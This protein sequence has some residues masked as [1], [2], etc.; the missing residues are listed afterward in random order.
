[1]MSTEREQQVRDIPSKMEAYAR[2][3][4]T[5]DAAAKALEG[6][7][8]IPVEMFTKEFEAQ[9][10]QFGKDVNIWTIF[11]GLLEK[12]SKEDL[13]KSGSTANVVVS[14]GG[15]VFNITLK[16][17][18]S[19]QVAFDVNLSMYY[20]HSDTKRLS[21]RD[22]NH[23]ETIRVLQQGNLVVAQKGDMRVTQNQ[24]VN[25]PHQVEAILA[26]VGKKIVDG[27]IQQDSSKQTVQPTQLIT[28]ATGTGKGGMLGSVASVYGNG[29]FVVPD[30]LVTDAVKEQE[31]F[32][33]MIPK[34]LPTDIKAEDVER[35]LKDNPYVVMSHSQLAKFAGN[36]EG[37]NIFLDEL[38]QASTSTLEQLKQHKNHILGVTA[39]P[40]LGLY[41]VLGQ[42]VYD[43]SL[44]RAQNELRSV[45]Q[46]VCRDGVVKQN[47][48]SEKV[49]SSLLTRSGKVG[50]SMKGYSKSN[51][52]KNVRLSSQV[53]GMV[54]SD[55]ENTAR[56]V[57]S[58][59][60]GLG[61][62]AELLGKL[63]KQASEDRRENGISIEAS[64][65][66]ELLSAQRQLIKYSMQLE[67]LKLM[68]K[69][70]DDEEKKLWIAVR[71]G[72]GDSIV[73]TKYRDAISGLS[74]TQL[75]FSFS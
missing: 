57:H 72:E 58:L 63:N 40:N 68:G 24:Y 20:L 39:T 61:S 47:E 70:S 54:F 32:V 66:L 73:A 37:Q 19:D 12:A 27:D 25:R 50:A 44:Y 64:I 71:N 18:S 75:L 2:L 45:R 36:L 15:K 43:L 30:D 65:S 31:H 16:K 8:S 59:L 53:Q 52:Q 33:G 22:I 14:V 49:V 67:F 13:F 60:S 56:Q 26:T 34:T 21:I 23:G 5:V 74:T 48:L 4:L 55:D 28:A 1:M 29:I 46:V 11:N 3:A 7:E 62:N 35:Y 69:I 6:G 51:P 10:V 42:P 41:G 17:V 38:H 9:A